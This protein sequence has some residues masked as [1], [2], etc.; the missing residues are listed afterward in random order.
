MR[1]EIHGSARKHGITDDDIRHAINF[2][3][4]IADLGEDRLLHLGPDFAGNLLE[5]VTLVTATGVQLVIHAMRARP[6]YQSQLRGFG[7]TN[8]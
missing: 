4:V 2:A 8:V 3:L 6:K 5:I 7:G 1:F